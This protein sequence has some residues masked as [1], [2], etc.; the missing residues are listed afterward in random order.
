MNP[1]AGPHGLMLH[2]ADGPGHPPTQGSLSADD[3]R[4]LLDAYD[5]DRLVMARFFIDHHQVAHEKCDCV[6]VTIDDGLRE[7]L[8]VFLPVLDEYHLTA[9]WNV[10][11]Q[12][13]VG[14][15]HSLERYRWIRNHAF[16]G[17]EE[18][19]REWRHWSGWPA[20]APEGYLSEYGYLSETDRDFR[21]WRNVRSAVL[22][23]NVMDKI[24][25]A[26]AASPLSLSH[27]LS[28]GDL[29]ALRDAG[30]VIGLHTHSHSTAFAGLSREQQA[31]E[32]ATSKFILESILG[33]PVTTASWPCGQMTEY[34][35]EWMRANGITLAWGATMQG[36]PPW[37]APRWSSGYWRAA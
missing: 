9:C 34:G 17:V 28:A 15:P 5:E 16:G 24:A 32:W 8:D 13:L 33:E 14:V 37:S 7:A 2:Y 6:V 3:L 22:Y 36:S 27:W 26:G 19:Y 1:P 29:R 4:R 20:H 35:V 11:T 31:T 18:F 12:P 23:Q 21:W 30:H 25:A 10:Y